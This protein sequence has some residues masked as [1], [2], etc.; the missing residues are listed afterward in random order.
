M[1]GKKIIHVISNTHWDREW[2][3]PFEETRLLLLDFMD[4]LLDLLDN[5]PEFSSF[6]FDSQVL[7][8]L[9]YLELRPENKFRVEKHV[10][11]G[12]LIIGPWYSLPEEF[13]VN[14][15]SLVRNLLV[16]HRKAQALGAVSKT[17]YT[18][19]S[20]GQ[21]SQMP[22]IYNG[23]DIDTIIFYRGINTKKSEFILEG[24]D[25]SQLL[26]MRFG[27]LSRFSYYFYIYR[28]VRYGMENDD[29]RYDWR[30]GAAPFR[31]ANAE[32]SR[33]HY[34]VLDSEKK[35][36]NIDKIPGQMQ[37]LIDDESQHF[38]T[39]HLVCMQGFDASNPDS[40][41]SDL[42]KLCQQACPEHEIKLS[43]LQ[44]FMTAMRAE[45]TEPEH[46][47]G[48]SRDPGSVGKWTHLYGDVISARPHLKIANHRAEMDIQRRAEPWSAMAAMAGGKYPRM[49][50]ER[51]WT[52]LL[53]NHPHDTITGGGIDQ[54]EKDSRYRTDQIHII[55]QGVKR[56]GM[57]QIQIQI[58]NSD[59]DERDVVLTVFNPSP[60]PRSGVI[61]ALID[62]PEHC[63]Y[64]AFAIVSPSGEEQKIQLKEEYSCGTLVRNLQDVSLELRAQR[65]HCHFQA[66]SIP[67]MGYKM[68]N[69][70]RRR[71]ISLGPGSVLIDDK[72]L[73][74]KFLKVEFNLNGTLNLASKSNGHIFHNLHY[75]EDC[76]EAGHS[77]IHQKPE[78][79]EIITSRDDKAEIKILE[80]G[81]L[82]ARV[83]VDLK[84]QIPAGLD[85]PMHALDR[86][87]FRSNVGR[88]A[89]KR[90]VRIQSEFILRKGARQLE[91]KTKIDNTCRDHRM[92]VIFPTRL[93]CEQSHS[94]T[95]FDVVA[96]DIHV[97]KDSPWFG[98][99]N[100][101][102]PMQR[103]VDM[104]DGNSGLAI[105]NKGLREYEAMDNA[106][107]SLAITL[108][109]AFVYRNCPVIGRYEVH[110]E[111]ALSQ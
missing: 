84:M 49:V 109:R 9:D 20:Y 79:D 59:L 100:P 108:F 58:D 94:E 81:P 55:S 92:R 64:N 26:G 15:E 78:R 29:W 96:R 68:Y 13:I 57:Q 50:L 4:D 103:F 101:T 52:L 38:S 90:T 95:A 80:A 30:R 106:D 23:F 85:D 41:E 105:L 37:R 31:L 73:E 110:P 10:K 72:T 36:W 86:A 18:P 66:D 17:G 25:G 102:W 61:S 47:Y 53:K 40:R 54:M 22:Q 7:G 39:R 12:R 3:Y 11:A 74:T 65:D 44:D 27:C 43:N 21:T 32:L 16:G 46:L 83:Q 99:E 75:F 19:F 87:E 67:A 107:R 2:G 56:R 71:Q 91:I 70:A 89:E 76:G 33:E 104:S 28:Q 111:M 63:G 77:W 8:L 97:K 51:A 35:Q 34:Y 62:L 6:T 14:G 93:D 82:L 5:D 60:F 98:R 45:I 1:N 24:P 88:L 48:E 42:I 69:L